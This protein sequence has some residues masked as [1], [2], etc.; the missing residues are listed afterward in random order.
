MTDIDCSF[1][2][3]D[4]WFRL[5]AC[6][7]LINVGRVLM[8][9]NERDPYYYSLGGGV[10]H[11]EST[12][13]AAKREVWEETGQEFEIERLA[14]IHEHFFTGTHDYVLSGLFCHELAFYYL[15]K[16]DPARRVRD[17][18]LTTDGVHEHLA[19]LE[20]GKLDDL[21]VPVYPTFFAAELQNLGECLKHIVTC[22][23]AVKR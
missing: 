9:R 11:G 12:Q 17:V 14:F 13:E 6:G 2:Q 4:R 15:M 1:T 23:Q 5:R 20:I 3:K 19:W 22:D 18:G 21:P 7:I 8:V 10:R 16:W